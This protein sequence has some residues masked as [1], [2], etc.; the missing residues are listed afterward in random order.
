M[1]NEVERNNTN[2]GACWVNGA[3]L[4]A[5]ATAKKTK[6][7]FTGVL[8]V[9]GVTHNISIWLYGAD[10]ERVEGAEE[11]NHD[12]RAALVALT[13]AAGGEPKMEGK[14]GGAPVLKIS[15]SKRNTDGY[16]AAP[17]KAAPAAKSS[18]AL[19]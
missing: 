7:V 12:I 13:R 10:S 17:A 8:D 15:I 2:R 5:D 1:S 16:S 9:D 18:A 3:G 4:K 19:F 6:P 11:I 14:T